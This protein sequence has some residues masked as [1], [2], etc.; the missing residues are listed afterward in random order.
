MADR[1][2]G[3]NGLMKIDLAGEQYL[4]KAAVE[5]HYR[6]VISGRPLGYV[7]DCDHPDFGFLH[8]LLRHHDRRA[9]KIG[10][11]VQAFYI[12]P[13]SGPRG[14]ANVSDE[15]RRISGWSGFCR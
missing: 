13:V 4:S 8:A 7:F 5:R 14:T 11:G 12:V 3:D 6:A 2:A 10:S 9:E 1:F 15:L